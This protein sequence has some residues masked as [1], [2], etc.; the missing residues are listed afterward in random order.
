MD[1]CQYDSHG[2]RSLSGNWCPIDASLSFLPK[3]KKID[4]LDCCNGLLLCRCSKPYPETPDYVVCNPATEK[5]V[6]VPANKWSSDSYARLGFDPAISSHFHVF[7]LA[8]AAALNANVKFDYNIKEVGIYSSKAGAWTHQID[9]NDPFEICNFSAGTFLSGVLYLCSDND[10]VAAVDVEGNCRF[11]PAP[12]L[13]DACGRHDVYVSQ[14]QL[15]VAYY[16]AAEASIWV[17]ED[18]SIEDYW[19]LKHNISYLQLFGSRSRGRYGVISVHPEDDVIFI[20][21]ESKSTL[22]G[23]RLLLKLFSYEIDSKEL[24]F[25]C[26]LGRISRRPYLS[27]VPLF[28]ESLADEH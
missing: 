16:G 14:G 9:W 6:I 17:L 27:Y 8:P 5:W 2:Y 24:K 22:S 18:S 13:D 15:Y 26:D 7:E 20:T 3:Y 25:I 19:T 1:R 11:I 10:L 23:D 12:T 21:V 4:L 28:S